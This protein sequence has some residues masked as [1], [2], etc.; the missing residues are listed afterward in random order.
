MHLAPA[1]LDALQ[2]LIDQD[3]A[4]QARIR[5]A[6]NVDQVVDV[7]APAASLQGIEVKP[8]TLAAYLEAVARAA[9]ARTLS[10]AQLECVAGGAKFEVPLDQLF[11]RGKIIVY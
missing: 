6:G 5:S 11:T 3:D 9:S 4:L 1:T 8:S 7:I 10:D 2:Q